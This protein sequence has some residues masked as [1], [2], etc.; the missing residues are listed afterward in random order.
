MVTWLNSGDIELERHL[1]AFFLTLELFFI[2]KAASGIKTNAIFRIIIKKLSRFIH[3]LNDLDH[4]H[5][6][7][8]KCL[9]SPSGIHKKSIY[10]KLDLFKLIRCVIVSIVNYKPS[11]L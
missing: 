9:Y 1:S 10:L 4:L 6:F 7:R 11:N 3:I 5:F 2:W 8:K